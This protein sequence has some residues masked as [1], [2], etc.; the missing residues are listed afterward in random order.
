MS[1]YQ[2]PVDVHTE[3][4]HLV[5]AVDDILACVW[6]DPVSLNEFELVSVKH[7]ERL[8]AILHTNELCP[9]DAPA[10]QMRGLQFQTEEA[11]KRPQ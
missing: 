5:G 2:Q 6:I 10:H 8:P 1:A 9:S 4:L 11:A 3:G 7:I